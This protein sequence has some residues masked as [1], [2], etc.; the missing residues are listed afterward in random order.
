[1][2]LLLNQIKANSWNCNYM[3]EVE[4]EALK[5]RLIAQGPEVMDPLF[6]RLMP[7]GTYE[8]VDG[9][10]RWKIAK[11]LGWTEIE[12]LVLE[13]MND[14]TAKA[15]CVSS[16]LLRGHVNWFKLA[17]VVKQDQENGINLTE[18][19]KDILSDKALKELFSLDNL[20]PKARLDLEEAVKKFQT[21]TLYDLHIIAQF[22]AYLQEELAQEYKTHNIA[23]HSLTQTLSK[24]IKQTQPPN[25]TTN[26]PYPPQENEKQNSSLPVK[27]DRPI[28]P[29]DALRILN[30]KKQ[31]Q[32]NQTATSETNQ[33]K[34]SNNLNLE[35][36]DNS[37]DSSSF[38]DTEIVDESAIQKSLVLSGGYYCACGRLH[39]AH[40]KDRIYLKNIDIVT[41]KEN[42]IFEHVDFSPHIFLVHCNYCNTDQQ[43]RVDNHSAEKEEKI[44]IVCRNCQ[45][46]RG[47]LLD[48]TTG[49][50]VWFG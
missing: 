38:S 1:M 7:D 30:A 48:V 5:Q 6:V 8:I 39:R 35:P 17:E 13:P 45:P 41:Q 36:F 47:G 4:Q 43:V 49:D 12:V 28:S 42:Q 15:R 3:G 44:P 10:H 18:T 20:V 25:P 29:N 9:E 46:A 21:I 23:S 33:T 50:A 40:F 14:L 26:N 22:P 31:Q 34:T 24:Y 11:E 27:F 16:S 37:S 32:K 19:Y 2:K